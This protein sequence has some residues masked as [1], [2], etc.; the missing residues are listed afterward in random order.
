MK[1]NGFAIG[2]LI[3]TLV[4]GGGLVAL[5]LQQGKR[6]A[7]LQAEYSDIKG[8]VERMARVE[9]FPNQEN[10]EEREK[11]VK[12]F[13]GKVEGL[14]NAMQGF[15]PENLEKISPSEFQNRLVTKTAAIKELFA[16][17]DI[18]V[19]EQFAFGMESYLDG[20]ANPDATAKL[21][22]QLEA[23]DWL[24]RQLAEKGAYEIRN[25]VR[26]ALP[27]ESGQVWSDVYEENREDIP[28]AQSMPMEVIFLADEAAAN[29]FI[30][31][32]VSSKDYFFAVDSVRISNENTSAP[33]RA[34]S[35]LEEMD[36]EE[37][38][39][40]GGGGF[41]GFGD[42]DFDDGEEEEAEA[43]E[44]VVEEE[45]AEV[46]DSGLILGQIA[47]RE[48]VYIGLQIRLLLFGDPIELPEIN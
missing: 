42:F 45:E 36:E 26:E 27:S 23:S 9:P 13:R 4:I 44:E 24:F 14:Q 34:Q 32:L 31:Q 10:L 3:G 19:P 39:D 48:G 22:Y 33:V 28:L 30:N 17:K 35:G 16:E 37:E 43:E 11:E 38:E 8:E 15:R 1:E 2:L 46:V 7:G 6:Y 18:S 29:E 5:G 40:G 20:L 41:G 25:V 47:G 21:N 12:A